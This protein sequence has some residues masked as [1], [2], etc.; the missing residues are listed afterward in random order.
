M[1]VMLW[2]LP[3]RKTDP[4]TSKLAALEITESGRRQNHCEKIIAVLIA[5][6]VRTPAAAWT[7][8]EIT[9]GLDGEVSRVNK[10]LPDCQ[11]KGPWPLDGKLWTLR[12][13]PDRA[14][15]VR[16][17]ICQTYYVQPDD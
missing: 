5:Q 12:I 14:C 16:G 6:N 10:R 4:V 9:S 11:R 8:G 17:S 7:H 15:R 1:E 2:D 13:G 3:C